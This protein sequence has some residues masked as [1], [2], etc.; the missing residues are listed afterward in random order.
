MIP[1]TDLLAMSLLEAC[2]CGTVP[3]LNA[4]PVYLA[5]VDEPGSARGRLRGMFAGCSPDGGDAAALLA[6]AFRMWRA[7][8]DERLREVGAGNAAAVA[9]DHDW[10]RNADLM[11]GVYEAALKTHADSGR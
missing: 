6:A 5:S 11:S 9:R 7:T 4:L 1:R 2:A 10:S 3:I 8:P